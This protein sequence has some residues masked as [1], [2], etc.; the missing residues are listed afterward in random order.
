M[1]TKKLND[2]QIGVLRLL[3]DGKSAYTYCRNMAE[4]GARTCT[5]RA[6]RRRGYVKIFEITDDGRAALDAALAQAA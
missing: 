4:H 6:L 5:V 1:S 2:T 3:A